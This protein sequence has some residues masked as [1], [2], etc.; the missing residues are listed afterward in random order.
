MAK[1]R[2]PRHMRPYPE[3]I[4]SKPGHWCSAGVKLQDLQ[5][6]LPYLCIIQLSAGNRNAAS[7]GL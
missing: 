5:L 3:T 2:A 1:L 6:P 7:S 4:M